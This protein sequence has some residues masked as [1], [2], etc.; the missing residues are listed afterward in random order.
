MSWTMGPRPVVVGVDGSL[1][2]EVAVD[3]AAD[4]ASRRNL[5]LHLLHAWDASFTAE[6]VGALKA[7]YEQR[8]AKA[9]QAASRR[10]LARHP[11]LRLSSEHG[12]LGA[13]AALVRASEAADTIVVGTHGR[14]PVGRV[15]IGSVS[16]EVATHSHCPVVVVP[17]PVDLDAP[18]NVV[19]GVDGSPAS[20]DAV[21]YAMAYAAQT[22]SDL[23]VVHGWDVGLIDGTLALNAQMEVWEAF[24]DQ[25]ETMVGEV[26]AGWSEKYPDVTV[27]SRVVR[28]PAAAALLSASTDAQLLVVGSRGHGGFAGLLLGSVSRKV[29]HAARCPVAVVHTDNVRTSH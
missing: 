6:M 9:L 15:L 11:G 25:R 13:A 21:S 24:E 23:T 16:S 19:V 3:W 12:D 27:H 18:K 5:P 7:A 29:L 28:G 14:G 26:A 2:G 1:C 10:A 8:A 22:D 4:E 20:L 17:E